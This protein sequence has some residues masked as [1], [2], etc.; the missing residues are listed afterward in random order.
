MT[1]AAVTLSTFP[2]HGRCV[3]CGETSTH[4][5][6]SGFQ[7]RCGVLRRSVLFILSLLILP[8]ISGLRSVL[9]FALE[10]NR[11]GGNGA[12]GGTILELFSARLRQGVLASSNAA[13]ACSRLTPGYCFR[14]SSSVSPPSK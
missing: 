10:E 2:N 13:T 4:S 7:R 11:Y 5:R 14:N 3:R 9:R 1:G 12:P 8:W 6:K